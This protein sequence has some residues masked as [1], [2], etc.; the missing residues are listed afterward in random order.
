[1]YD[2]SCEEEMPAVDYYECFGTKPRSTHVFAELTDSPETLDLAKFPIERK[3]RL[4]PLN[5]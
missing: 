4:F 5:D 1:M 2:V 3:E